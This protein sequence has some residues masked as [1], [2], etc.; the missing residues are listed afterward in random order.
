MVEQGFLIESSAYCCKKRWAAATVTLTRRS[1]T[2]GILSQWEWERVRG[3]P[4]STVKRCVVG[5]CVRKAPA[6]ARMHAGVGVFW[7]CA[8][9]TAP[10]VGGAEKYARGGQN[11]SISGKPQLSAAE[12]WTGGPA[13]AEPETPSTACRAR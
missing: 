12:T 3:Q 9:V 8:S 13:G 4:P 2:A 5:A 6:P 10:R 1:S 11:K 7:P